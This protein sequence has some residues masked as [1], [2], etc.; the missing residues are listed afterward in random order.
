MNRDQWL[1]KRGG[2]DCGVC[3]GA[4]PA[5]KR[6]VAQLPSGI[7]A[8]QN[9]GDFRGYCILFAQR[10]VVELHEL[11]AEER[12]D[13]VEDAAA[14]S[15]AVQ[16]VCAPDKL[17]VVMLGNQTPHLHC[18]IIPRYLADGWWGRPIWDR[19]PERRAV[20][21]DDE[22]QRLATHLGQLLRERSIG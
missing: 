8:L 20:L 1:R 22:G 6:V 16:D 5:M 12:R 15:A 2:A 21:G 4:D 18:H 10:H 3:A 17:N 13:W 14:I 9:D 19:P 7:V 11:T